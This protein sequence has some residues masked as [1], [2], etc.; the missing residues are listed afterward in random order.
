ML[1]I[2]EPRFVPLH[3]NVS[4]CFMASELVL[5]PGLTARTKLRAPPGIEVGQTLD[6]TVHV[7]LD[8]NGTAGRHGLGRFSVGLS[9][10]ADPDGQHRAEFALSGFERESTTALLAFTGFDPIEIGPSLQDEI[11][12]RPSRR[13]E[14]RVCDWESGAPIEGISPSLRYG[15]LDERGF[16]TPAT[17]YDF[18]H[19]DARQRR[20]H[21]LAQLSGIPMVLRSDELLMPGDSAAQITNLPHLDYQPKIYLDRRGE[22]SPGPI[23]ILGPEYGDGVCTLYLKRR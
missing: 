20:D 2:F 23:T 4:T 8:S 3:M 11:L 12:L 17:K 6:C 18:T 5:D 14:L 7:S 13:L 15:V 22:A 19:F 21:R 9:W 10:H 1:T 16:F